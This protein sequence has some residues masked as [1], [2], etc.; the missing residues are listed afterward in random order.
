MHRRSEGLLSALSGLVTKI[1]MSI[2]ET[3]AEFF[4]EFDSSGRHTPQPG[5]KPG[6]PGKGG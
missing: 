1:K 2:F 6:K 3:F 4:A 5:P